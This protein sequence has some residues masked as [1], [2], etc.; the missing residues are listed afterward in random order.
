MISLP[1]VH[2]EIAVP[3]LRVLGCCL[4]IAGVSA[5]QVES[6]DPPAA[7]RVLFIGNSLTYFND[8][9][10]L[11]EHLARDVGD[12]SLSTT[13]VAFPNFSL[14]DHWDEG[15]ARRE[16]AASRWTHVV[17]QQGPS[18]LPENALLLQE[19]SVKFERL[20]RRAGAQPVLYMVWPDQSRP[21]DFERVRGS[22]RGAAQAVNG[23][24]APAGD[25]WALALAADPAAPLYGTDGFHPALEGSWLAAVV[26]LARIR[27]LDPVSLPGV[28]PRSS[29]PEARVRALQRAASEALARNPARP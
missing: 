19:W 3:L 16:L 11:V 8:L 24:F 7:A 9:P 15:T 22:Y 28:I 14:A 17:L 20:I 2:K 25:A 12:T 13:M 26:L 21:A 23:I 1:I 18:S 6:Q 29:L 10:E 27:G 5:C 4:V